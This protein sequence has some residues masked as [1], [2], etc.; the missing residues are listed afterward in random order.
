MAEKLPV[1]IRIRGL[2]GGQRTDTVVSGELYRIGGKRIVR[3]PEPDA[4]MNGTMTTVKIG[5]GEIR[6]LRHGAVESEQGF[7]PGQT[8]RGFYRVGPLRLLLETQAESVEAVWKDAKGRV[9]WSY[10]LSV[11]GQAQGRYEIDLEIEEL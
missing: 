8:V 3:Y 4:A 5:D 10:R 2:G 7:V 1:R 11:D 6:V 9:Q